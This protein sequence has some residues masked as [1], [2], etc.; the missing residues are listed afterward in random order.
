MDAQFSIRLDR[1]T[2]ESVFRRVYFRK[3]RWSFATF[4]IVSAVFFYV[5]W[6]LGN[7]S[8]LSS[9]LILAAYV[10]FMFA[11]FAFRYAKTMRLAKSNIEKWGD[12]EVVYRVTDEGLQVTAPQG[13]SLTPWK[14]CD[15]LWI[16]QDVWL[17]FIDPINCH[18]LPAAGLTG[19]AG[20]FLVQKVRENGGKVK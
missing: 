3:S 10:L 8:Y 6:S 7:L 1:K 14:A 17:L 5:E 20:E 4:A 12:R 11:Y 19:E 2:M 16:Y 9:W 18:V 13:S 15:A